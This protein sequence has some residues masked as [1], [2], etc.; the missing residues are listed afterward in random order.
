MC[1]A[2]LCIEFEKFTKKVPKSHFGCTAVFLLV[3]TRRALNTIQNIHTYKY[4]LLRG[5]GGFFLLSFQHCLRCGCYTTSDS[6]GRIV[7]T[8]LKQRTERGLSLPR[9]NQ[10]SQQA[11]IFSV[12]LLL[13]QWKWLKKGL[14]EH[15]VELNVVWGNFIRDKKSLMVWSQS[16]TFIH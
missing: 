3:S 14:L 13:L 1:H 8:E 9:V 7:F 16:I 12:Y 6:R 10:P 2:D 11:S 4:I 5:S 15:L